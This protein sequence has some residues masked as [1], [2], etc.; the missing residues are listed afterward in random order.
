MRPGGIAV[1]LPSHFAIVATVLRSLVEATPFANRCGVAN[2]AYWVTGTEGSN[3]SLSAI[4]SRLCGFTS[5]TGEAHDPFGLTRRFHR[6]SRENR[7]CD[8]L[9][10]DQSKLARVRPRMLIDVEHEGLGWQEQFHAIAEDPFI[11]KRTRGI[12]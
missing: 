8:P 4:E 10:I 6:Y 12:G 2:L 3:P 9:R 1:E 5:R 7:C 11:E